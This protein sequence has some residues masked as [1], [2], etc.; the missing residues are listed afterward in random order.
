MKKYLATAALA[1]GM[2]VLAVPALAAQPNNQACL[3]EDYSG[4]AKG[5]RPLG[6]ALNGLGL[7]DGGLGAEV[8]AHLAGLV[9]DDF[10]PNSCND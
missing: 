1:A 2:A 8:Q 4:Y 3:G 10:I 7:T 6:Q 9:P 5:L